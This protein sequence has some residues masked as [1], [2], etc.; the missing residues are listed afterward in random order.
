[1][2]H[3]LRFSELCSSS[4]GAL[5]LSVVFVCAGATPLERQELLSRQAK[6]EALSPAE[7]QQLE[8]NEQRFAALS[9]AEQ[10]QLRKLAD[11]L[12]SDPAEA[13]LKQLLARYHE[14]LKTLSPGQRAELLEL[15]IA[16]RVERIKQIKEQQAR[17]RPR[18]PANLEDLSPNDLPKIAHWFDDS[19]WARRQEIIKSLG[20]DAAEKLEQ[21]PE[22]ERRR[23]LAFSVWGR[24]HRWDEDLSPLLMAETSKLIDQLSPAAAAKF[25]ATPETER[26]QLM[27]QWL[28]AAFAD[29][30]E[31]RGPGR[32]MPLASN[33]EIEAFFEKSL[34]GPERERLL[35]MPRDEMQREL[36]RLY[37]QYSMTPE[38]PANRGAGKQGAGK[39]GGRGKNSRRPGDGPPEGERRG[40]R[41]GKQLRKG[42][43]QDTSPRENP[44][45]A[46][47]GDASPPGQSEP[48]AQHDEPPVSTDSDK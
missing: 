48:P 8:R 12:E 4:C 31:R 25:N 17:H 36:R 10:D 32:K 7:K 5:V 28:R 33:E 43:P 37:V 15:P 27:R 23:Y 24:L 45:R 9:T 19:I 30:M 29:R 35:N 18:K 40:P 38:F 2:R 22:Q 20:P 16:E 26:R 1:M 39:Q 13:R 44:Q 21:M 6:V 14:W 11:D 3:K 34:P 47:D 42:P 41:D 46:P